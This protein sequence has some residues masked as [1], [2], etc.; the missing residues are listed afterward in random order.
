[1]HLSETC[2]RVLSPV[3]AVFSDSPSRICV[4]TLVHDSGGRANVYIVY[5]CAIM[6]SSLL[7]LL[8][9]LSY[10]QT[11]VVHSY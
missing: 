1:M 3:A 10:N 9:E 4:T 2:A 8:H 7:V 11:L 5:N 6:W